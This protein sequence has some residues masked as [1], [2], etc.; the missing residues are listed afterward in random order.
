VARIEVRLFGGLADRAGTARTTVEVDEDATVA[1]LRRAV[2]TAHPSLAPL[3]DRVNVAVDLEVARADQPLAGARGFAR[4]PPVAGGAGR[5]SPEGVRIVTGLTA[6]PLAVDATITEVT[7]PEVGGTAVFLGTVRDHAPDLD[8]VIGLDYSAYPEM[9]ER[10]LET[11]ADEL[12]VE[13]PD[14]RGIALL[15]SVGELRVGD[16]TILI[17][18]TAAHRRAA[19]AACQDA[20]ERV[21]DRVPVWKRERTAIGET[22]W[23]GLPDAPR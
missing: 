19:F 12:V 5:V 9:A 4:L 23:V 10:V 22:R 15:H 14:V 18:C 1:D 13:H 16:H 7:G 11:I 21:K 3:L 17:V 8:E 6:P 2:A 20:L